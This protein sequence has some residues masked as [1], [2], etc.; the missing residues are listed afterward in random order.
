MESIRDLLCPD[1]SK[2]FF[3]SCWTFAGE[4]GKR[5]ARKASAFFNEPWGATVVAGFTGASVGDPKGY[6]EV[7]PGA[8]PSWPDDE[9]GCGGKGK[10]KKQE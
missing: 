6:H 5:F 7:E 8:D 10:V 2:I 9:G 4:M 1:G 3:R